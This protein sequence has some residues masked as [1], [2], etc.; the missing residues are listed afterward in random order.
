MPL[1]TEPSCEYFQ[2]YA[3]SN[4]EYHILIEHVELASLSKS[5]ILI[6]YLILYMCNT[7]K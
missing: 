5:L 1:Y 4:C 3:L 6:I 7:E 2:T